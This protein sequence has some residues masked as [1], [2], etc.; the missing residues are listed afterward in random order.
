MGRDVRYK[1]RHGILPNSGPRDVQLR[2]C[3]HGSI[4]V[5]GYIQEVPADICRGTDVCLRNGNGMVLLDLADGVSR[6]VE[7]SDCVEEWV[8][9]E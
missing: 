6:A 1:F 2:R 3:E 7:L 4:R 5:Y 8:Y 9:A